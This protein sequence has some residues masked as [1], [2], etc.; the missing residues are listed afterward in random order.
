M[1]SLTRKR[2]SI[3]GVVQGV[4]FRP[5]VWQRASS[6]G[7]TG[8]VENDSGGVTAEVQGPADRVAA[9]LDG[10]AAAAPP[11]ALVE[12]V[13]VV[14][15]AIVDA[16]VD[17][18]VPPRFMILE[19]ITRPGATTSLP[20][21][22]A[23]CDDC[24]AE[25]RDPGNRRFR[26]PFTNC[27]NCGPRFT[28]ITG[29][30]YDRPQTTMRGFAMC[31]Q[32]AAEYAEPTDRRF[33][34]QPNA[35]PAC[36]PSVWLSGGDADRIAEGDAAF[37]A[38]KLLLRAG[39]IVA[40]KGVGGFHLVCDATS[41]AAVD[42]LRSRKQRVGKPLA[43]MV[44][45]LAAARAIASV[46]EQ[47]RR[48]LEGRERPIVLLRKRSVDVGLSAEVSPGN[49]FVGVMLPYAPLHHLLCESMPPLVMT[50]GNLSEEPIVHENDAAV[51]RLGPL[52]DAFL[53]H[54]RPIHVACDDS[55][56]RCAAGAV[57]PIRRS[58]GYAAMPIRLERPGP[59]VLAVGG[60]LK[61]TICLAHADQAIMSQHIGDMGNLETLES[62][63][64][65][66][67]HLLR[68][69]GVTPTIVAA[70]LHPGSLSTGW[71]RRFAADRGIPLVQVQHHE[72]HVAS[73]LAEHGRPFDG[74]IGVCFDGTGYGHDGT[75]WGG[76]FCAVSGGAFRRA[77]HLATFPLPG[78]DASIRHPWRTALA[79]L[80]AAGLEW[81]GRLAP[82]RAAAD[83]ERRVLGQQLA[84]NINCVATS[85][86]GRLFDAVA[87]LAGVK[88]SITYEAEAAMRLEALAAGA[89]DDGGA[90]AF[91]V[92][93]AEPLRV[94]WQSVVGAVVVDVLA[95][96][97]P[98]RIAARFHAAVT[99]M[100][101]DVCTRLRQRGAG[102]TVGLTGGVFQN[103]LVLQM[104]IGELHQAGFEVLVHQRVPANDG[105]LALGQAVLARLQ[106]PSLL[107]EVV[108][109]LV[110][111]RV[112]L[113]RGLDD[114]HARPDRFDVGPREFAVELAGGGQIGL[115]DRGDVGGVEEPR[116]FERLVLSL[117]H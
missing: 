76:E 32:C 46:D 23:T 20:A 90:Y 14:D 109:P 66:A 72:A 47:E 30:P 50:S 82:V 43:V 96:V 11:L 94:G 40:I 25:I 19:S 1:A 106:R 67:S 60:E 17:M 51:Q 62:L 112:V 68:L 104:A 80:H 13:A 59:A 58:R 63:D 26:Y 10:F 81:D 42:L 2:L 34:A 92:D 61:A 83:V 100:I 78:G 65:T 64:H 85:S 16:D 88:Q 95:G 31:S 117:R 33:H 98:D 69:F 110:D 105:G 49:G 79:V 3:S 56:V 102:G 4:G 103:A 39:R 77:A 8:W 75:I 111:A 37:V 24:L 45:D 48:L 116:I 113:H 44:E 41:D 93:D 115:R 84:K 73:L 89:T 57:M 55:V 21:D 29:L 38:V 52:V 5:F 18:A 54:D 87:A 22:S 7:L 71:A 97:P 36:G 101:V 108:E 53:M 107:G 35:C 91:T 99:R 114:S 27:T 70:D 12:R 74:V 9:F 86:M 6:F 28:L 15:I